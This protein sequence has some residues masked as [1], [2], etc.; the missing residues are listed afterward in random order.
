[1]G[2][3]FRRESERRQIARPSYGGEREPDSHP[4]PGPPT[5]VQSARVLLVPA[6]TGAAEQPGG[7]PFSGYVHSVAFAGRTPEQDMSPG[8]WIAASLHRS[9][10]DVG[11]LVPP[12]FPA[13][14]RVL[15]PAVRYHGDDDVEVAWAEV[16]AHNGTVAHPLAQ[17][18]TL[19][20][21]WEYLE[22]D[23]QPPVWDR[24]P[25][26]GHLPV[27]TA[28]RLT[29]VLRGHTTT[30][31]DCFFGIWSGSGFLGADAPTLVLPHR[32]LWLVRG[33]IDLATANLADEPSEQSA[34]LWWP[35]DRS[36]LVATDIDRMSTYVGGSAGC[37][38]D[39]LAADGVEAVP[40]AADQSIRWDADTV[41]PAP[42]DDPA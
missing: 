41:N 17:W 13:Y 38:A 14:A 28:R 39:V 7:C 19:T 22:E 36:W 2:R 33:P 27:D 40:A 24:A 32:E 1:M 26:E 12:T 31:D 3:P 11:S 18:P 29:A 16:A 4:T 35:A 15:H 23:N 9:L 37:V 30:P 10:S 8:A 25:D 20:G 21:S 42:D 5:F 34:H 6:G